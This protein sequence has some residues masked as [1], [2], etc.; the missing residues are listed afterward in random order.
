MGSIRFS[1]NLSLL[2]TGI[3]LILWGVFA[4]FPTILTPD[5]Q[6]IILGILALIAGVLVFV[7]YKD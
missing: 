4:L 7:E 3:W 2:L 5:A 1:R 6:R